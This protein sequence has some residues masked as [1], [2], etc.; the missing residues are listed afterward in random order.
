MP[1]KIRSLIP[2]SL[3]LWLLVLAAGFGGGCSH[4]N[5]PLAPADSAWENTDKGIPAGYYDTVN[6][7]TA[8]TLRSTLHAVIDDHLKISYTS[9][10]TDTWIVVEAA[11]TDPADSGRVLDVYLNASFPKYGEGNLDYN[12]EHVWAKSYGFPNDGASNYPYTD[13][14]HLFICNDSYNSSRGNE[15]YGTVG[16]T[17][18][19]YTTVANGGVGGGSGVYPGWSNWSDATY[20]ETWWDRRGDV[21]RALLYMDVRYDGG[22]HGVTGYAEPDLILTDSLAQIEASNTGANLSVAY[23]GLLSVVLQWHLDDPVDAKEQ[24]RNDAVYAYQG[25]RNPFI[26]HPE[27]VACLFLANCGGAGDTTPPAA[28]TGLVAVGGAGVVDLNWNDNGETDLAGYTVYRATAAGGPYSAL[29]G[30]LL[31][32]SDYSDTAVT[33]GTTY[34]YVVTADDAT[35][36]ESAQSASASA[37][38]TGGGGGPTV[39][40]NEF[41]YDNDGTDSGELVEVAGTAGTSLAGWTVVG[42]NGSGGAVYYTANLSGT[43]PNQLSGFGTASFAFV[44]MQ[45]GSPDGLAL[46]DAAGLVVQFLS[47]EGSFTAV[48]GA[49]AGMASTDIGVSEGTTS[50]VGWTLQL[51]GSGTTYAAFTWQP[52]AAGTAGTVNTGQTFGTPPPNVAPVAE[53]NGPYAGLTGAAIAFSSTGSTDSDGTITAWL[54]NFGDGATSTAANPSHAYATAGAY[55]VTLTVTDDD[56][57]QGGDTA[58][59]TVTAPNQAPVAQANGPYS[60]TSGVAIAFSSAGSTDSDGTITAWLWNFGDGATS[61]AANPTHAYAATGSY[62]ATLTVTDNSGAQS[63]DT[64]PVTVSAPALANVWINEFHYDNAGTDASEFVEVAGP[65][66]TDL[67]GWTVVAYNGADGAAYATSAL[68][69]T[70]ANLQNGYGVKS[71]TYAGLQNGSPDG[72][73]LVNPSGQVV[74]FL[75]YEGVFTAV[76]GA[77]GGLTSTNIPLSES[78]ATAK[79]TSLQLRGT[80]DSY[81]EFTWYVN[82]KASAGKKNTSQTFATVIAQQ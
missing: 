5:Q 9:T 35:G 45:N 11:D 40:I 4:E 13:C 22:T 75:S 38:P 77:A 47:Y 61:T 56:G 26:D 33:G 10:G 63:S 12:R 34:W 65:A 51:A 25:N 2:R 15:P 1:R 7:G 42:Y 8:A 70:I 6:A 62:T 80:G 73:A 69:G 58:G 44:G 23:M 82:L 24:A 32:A 50:P 53:A 29:N 64:A 20:W 74:Q 60:G 59:V 14:H 16:A 48:D 17:G 52:A 41:H 78:E 72:I 31:T 71:I 43:L 28:P 36:N 57:A 49:A 68:S 81:A 21:A 76:G 67:T 19:E 27:W 3:V 39:W 66:G 55:T 79:G 37:T 54:W 46:V 30:A 18:T